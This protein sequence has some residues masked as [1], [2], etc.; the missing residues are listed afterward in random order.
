MAKLEDYAKT[1]RQREVV[2][3]W[4]SCDRH[5]GKAAQILGI[6]HATV[7][8]IVT[9][10]KGAAAA[11][12]FS[13]AWDATEHVPEGEYVTGRS[14]YLEDDSGNKAWLKTRRKLETA[15]KEEALKA[16]V[17]QL[18]SQV[19]QAKKTPKPS[20]KGKSKDLLPTIIIGDAHIGMRAEASETRDRD[21][22]SQVASAE[23]LGAIDYLVD[24]APACEEAM[25]INVGDFMHANSH[26]NTTANLTPLDVDQRIESVMRIAADTMIHAI[27]RILE[28]HSKVSVVMA[29]GN[30]DSDTAIAIAMVLGYRYAKEPRVTILE[31]Q[32]FHTYTTFGK[33]LIAVTHGDKAPSRRLADVL[34]RL[35][36]WS[37]TSHRY[38]ILGHFHSKLAEQFDNSVV[39]ERF[40]TLAPSDSWHASKFYKSP[41]IMNQ[42]VYRRSGGIA[43]R[44]EYEIPGKDYEPDHEI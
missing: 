17:E 14:I 4:E 3:V 41:S 24:A 21:F 40:G 2:K 32:G 28:K 35:S 27:T 36:V 20:A 19:K 44:H 12:G 11:A 9:T 30:H 25:L 13:D 7:R 22:N 16:F 43:I 29:R 26:K 23:L 6:T 1:E 38:W 31:P 15:E 8:N 37:K 5:S 39:V 18:N 42:I 10:V 34:P 33:N